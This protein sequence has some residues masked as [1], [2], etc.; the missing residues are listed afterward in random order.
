MR[1]IRILLLGCFVLLLSN[2]SSDNNNA[3]QENEMLPPVARTQIPDMAFE[4]ALIEL[5]IDDVEDGFVDKS[6]IQMVTSLVMNNKGITN[7]TGIADFPILENLG[8]NGNQITTLDVSK[9]TRLKFLFIEN[10]GLT[11]IN[12]SNLTILEKLE[13][14]NN[15]LTILDIADNTALQLLRLTDN[16]VQNIDIS[17]IPN[18]LQLNTFSVEKNPLDCIK[19]NEETLSNIPSQWTKDQTDSYA[20]ECN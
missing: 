5:R 13:V 8:V 16:A 15:A 12:V 1:N 20:L 4:R 11:S 7:L 3:I 2:C 17:K 9:N 14:S 18:N 6:D 19:V 10:N